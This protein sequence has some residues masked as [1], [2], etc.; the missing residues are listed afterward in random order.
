M[1]PF[2][3]K[4]F[5]FC[6]C[7]F[8]VFT[9]CFKTVYAPWCGHCKSMAPAYIELAKEM[10]GEDV[11]VAE[12]DATMNESPTAYAYTGFP[13]MF[14]KPA[15]SNVP[16]KYESGRDFASMSGFISEK[17]LGDSPQKDEL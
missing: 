14:W 8:Q 10:E 4:Q 3:S 9:S 6:C 1:I 13:T 17:L 5:V 12:I 15:G 2:H 16:E 11:I 7:E